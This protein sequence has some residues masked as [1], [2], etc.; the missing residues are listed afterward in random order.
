[1]ALMSSADRKVVSRNRHQTRKPARRQRSIGIL[2]Q[3]EKRTLLTTMFGVTTASAL[4][5]FDS[6]APT[7]ILKS[8]PITNI[9]AG[10]TIQGIDYRPANGQLYA[11]T[12]DANHTGRLYTINTASAVATLASTIDVPVTGTR[13]GLDFNPAT[14]RLRVV[15]DTDLNVQ[16]DVTFGFATTDGPLAYLA[17]DPSFGQAPHL[18]GSAFLNNFA[19]ATATTLY[20]I[21]SNLDILAI[22]NLPNN[23]TLTTVGALGVDASEVAGFDIQTVGGTHF[24]YAALVVGGTTSLYQINLSTGAATLIAPV[25]ASLRALAIAPDPGYGSTVA[26]S[27]ATFTGS[28]H[29][30]TLV[31]DQVGGLLRHNQFALGTPGYHS[32]F[33]FDSTRPGDQTLSSTDTAISIII[34]TGAGDNQVTLGSLTAPLSSLATAFT[35]HGGG[36]SDHLT[37]DDRA[38]TIARTITVRPEQVTGLGGTV[39]YHGS[40]DR[41]LSLEVMAGMANDSFLLTHSLGFI[42]VRTSLDG[43]GGINTLNVAPQGAE[44]S[45]FMTGIRFGPNSIPELQTFIDL[46]LE[47]VNIAYDRASPIVTTP[48]L[49]TIN[50][51]AGTQFVDATVARFL[52]SNAKAKAADYQVTIQWG[53]GTSSAGII[54]NDANIPELFYVLGSH[55]YSASGRFNVTTTIVDTGSRSSATVWGFRVTTIYQAKDPVTTTSQILVTNPPIA[56]A[57]R[58]DPASD[59]GLS[60]QDGI[61]NDNTPTFTGT[62]SPGAVVRIYNGTDPAT[63]QLIATALADPNGAWQATVLSPLADGLYTNLILEAT[64]DDGQGRALGVLASLMVDTVGPTV[65]HLEFRRLH[66]QVRIAF[67]DDRSGLNQAN[68]TDRANYIL[69][70]SIQGTRRNRRFP[71]TGASTTPQTVTTNTQVIILTINHG[72]RLRA[73]RYTFTARSGGIEDLAGNALNGIFTGRFPSGNAQSGGNFMAGLRPLRRTVAVVSGRLKKAPT[74]DP[75]KS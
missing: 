23:G 34:N 59:T 33:D 19:G 15:S 6:A 9:G 36:V 32:A 25:A 62:S 10:E 55:R 65:T 22:Q 16:V 68:A 28:V 63:R 30:D 29:G 56:V 12:T 57:G 58:L 38:G 75:G 51:V 44:T 42:Y 20:Q 11:L 2:E 17:G 43:G 31:I 66:G 69:T 49:P 13:F 47:Q 1:M 24:G 41:Y 27:T 74:R 67:Q 48:P 70:G 5:Q 35:I 40:Y 18:A 7:I 26:G 8:N 4:V 61:T 52:E 45:L 21:D 73:G 3:C 60:D 54:V 71:I 72:R 46:N 14:D 53:D 64:S 39:S 37:L 50:A